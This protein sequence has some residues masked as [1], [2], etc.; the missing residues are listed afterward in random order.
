MKYL[1]QRCWAESGC[2][3][4][5]TA[6]GSDSSRNSNGSSSVSSVVLVDTSATVAIHSSQLGHG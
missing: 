1:I 2:V 4:C 5:V 3:L 6:G